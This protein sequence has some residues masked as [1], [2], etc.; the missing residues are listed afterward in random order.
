[1]LSYNAAPK[2][3]GESSLTDQALAT[4]SSAL[5]SG[6]FSVLAPGIV[7]RSLQRRQRSLCCG[8]LSQARPVPDPLISTFVRLLRLFVCLFVSRCLAVA[9]R[10]VKCWAAVYYKTR[11]RILLREL[12]PS[13]CSSVPLPP[14]VGPLLYRRPWG[15]IC[16]TSSCCLIWVLDYPVRSLA[17]S[18]LTG[19][20]CCSRAAG[21][22]C[23]TDGGLVRLRRGGGGIRTHGALLTSGRFQGGC[24]RPLDLSSLG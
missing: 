11:K 12:R 9:G 7:A 3:A 22:R 16:Y 1:M 6:W 18:V 23:G 20:C 8:Q 21:T 24:H 2:Y 14:L 17:G 13:V 4:A 19:G 10:R 5:S 15:I